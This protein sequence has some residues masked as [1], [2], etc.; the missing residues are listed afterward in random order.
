MA[1]K[2][3]SLIGNKFGNSLGNVA[4]LVVRSG[5]LAYTKK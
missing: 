4:G 2:G 1:F 5:Y 3:L